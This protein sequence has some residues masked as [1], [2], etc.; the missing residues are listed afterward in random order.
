MLGLSFNRP[1]IMGIVNVTPDSFSDGGCFST[2]DD[3]VSHIEQLISHGADIIDIG[4]QSTRPGAALISVQEEIERLATIIPLFKQR[5]DCLLSL[6][7]FYADVAKFGLENG[8]DIINDVSGLTYDSAMIETCAHY[9]A[10]VVIMHMNGAPKTMQDN[11]HYEDVMET[12]YSFLNQQIQRCTDVGIQQIMIDPG[13]G[14]GKTLDHNLSLL[15]NLATFKSLGYP[16]LIGT[17]R[18]SFI[19]QISPSDVDNRLGGSI[20]SNLRAWQ[21]GAQ[22]FRVHDVFDIKQA[23]DVLLRLEDMSC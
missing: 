13:I 11:P 9:Q 19:N 23:F 16:L 15:K 6:D 20:A 7:T 4:A 18:K 8:V 2:N 3:I 21:L 22:V 14:F 1:I 12:V 5:F 17:S 10:A